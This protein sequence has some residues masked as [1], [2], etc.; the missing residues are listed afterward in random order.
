MPAP[1]RVGHEQEHLRLDRHAR[2]LGARERDRRLERL[3]P[4][5]ERRRQDAVDL[6]ERALGM[7]AAGVEP[8]PSR[9]GEP[10]HH[11]HDLVVAQH[12]RRQPV[13]GP[14]AVAAADAPLALDRDAELLQVVDVAADGTA[15]DPEVVRDL[16]AA[17]DRPGLEQLED[18]EQA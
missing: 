2:G 7:V 13:A 11:H 4:S 3:D 5:P 18:L 17:H 9:R 10:D 1:D 14:Q 6:L 15:V 12:Q 16:A 8:E